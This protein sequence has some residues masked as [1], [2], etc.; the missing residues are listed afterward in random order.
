MNYFELFN[1]PNNYIIDENFLQKKYFSL[2]ITHHPDRAKNELERSENL[3][4]S[5]LINEA[6][7]ILKNSYTRAIYMLQLGGVT[8]DDSTLKNLLS[9]SELEAI[10]SQY[11]LIEDITDLAALQAFEKTKIL[12]QENLIQKI[13][14]SFLQN[15]TKQALDLT[16]KLKYLISLLENIGLKIKNANS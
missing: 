16:I 1:I 10:L 12:E 15:N 9:T 4:Y 11:E 5:M 3:K 13:G 8:F 7:K 14:L 2:Q 6:F